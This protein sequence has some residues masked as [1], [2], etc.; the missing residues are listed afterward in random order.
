MQ[1]TLDGYHSLFFRKQIVLTSSGLSFPHATF[2]NAHTQPKSVFRLFL[3]IRRICC[4]IQFLEVKGVA[5]GAVGRPPKMSLFPHAKCY[6]KNPPVLVLWNSC[7]CR[8]PIVS[9]TCLMKKDAYMYNVDRREWSSVVTYHSQSSCQMRNHQ[10]LYF[11]K[12]KHENGIKKKK[13]APPTLLSSDLTLGIYWRPSR[14][15]DTI[16]LNY[17]LYENVI[18][19]GHIQTSLHCI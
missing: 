12:L 5:L 4:S 13:Y 8:L 10:S 3:S 9:I 18:R 6:W 7:T 11:L 15:R 19:G 1:P 2:H 14:P 17:L 16:S